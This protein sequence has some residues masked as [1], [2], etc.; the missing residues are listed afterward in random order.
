[1]RKFLGCLVSL[2]RE[3]EPSI[4]ESILHDALGAIFYHVLQQA[5]H[6]KT[7]PAIYALGIFLSK[8][9]LYLEL[10]LCAFDKADTHE[11]VSPRKRDRGQQVQAIFNVLFY[12]VQFA[13]LAPAAGHTACTFSRQLRN[14]SSG[15][16]YDTESADLGTLWIN[17]LRDAL[18]TFPDSL[19]IFRSHVFPDLFSLSVPDYYTFL[20]SLDLHAQMSPDGV[21]GQHKFDNRAE[22]DSNILFLALQA[23]KETGLIADSGMQGHKRRAIITILYC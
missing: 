3:I 20:L 18:R 9:V 2:L 13:E 6:G 21:S 11:N 10:L 4:K 14:S 22:F 17:P 5:N 1:M 7:K 23:G 12:W 19:S 16:Q 15:D 8:E